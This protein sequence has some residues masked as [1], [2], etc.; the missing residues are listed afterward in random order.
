MADDQLDPRTLTG[1]DLDDARLAE[2]TGAF[3]QI[4]IEIE[5][6]RTLDLGETYPAVVFHSLAGRTTR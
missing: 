1:L 6:L 2:L 3:A 5:R 4:R